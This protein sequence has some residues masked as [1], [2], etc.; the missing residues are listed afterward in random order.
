MLLL[1]ILITIRSQQTLEHGQLCV[2]I[3]QGRMNQLQLPL[4]GRGPVLDYT[5]SLIHHRIGCHNSTE[6]KLHLTPMQIHNYGAVNQ[7]N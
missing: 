3:S 6:G 7:I 4:A 2:V 1:A 5:T